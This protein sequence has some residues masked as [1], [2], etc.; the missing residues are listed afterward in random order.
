MTKTR[1]VLCWL[2][3][4]IA[5][6]ALYAT[7]SQ[8]I[9]YL[10]DHSKTFFSFWLDTRANFATRSI[11]VDLGFLLLAAAVF[12]VSEAR[13]LKVRFVWLYLLL[14]FL[15]AISVTVPLFMIARERA[16]AKSSD[17]DPALTVLDIGI[18]ALTAAATL[19][20]A[21]VILR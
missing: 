16:L 8:N 7:W 18:L 19:G 4:L 12:M 20:L 10:G 2:Y 3:A 13:R 5:I 9:A 15:V 14:G 17:P 1:T 6:A 11:T 21:Y